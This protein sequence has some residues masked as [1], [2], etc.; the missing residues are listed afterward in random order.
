M[1]RLTL[2]LQSD[3][4]A[5]CRLNPD[6]PVPAWADGPGFVSITRTADELS[7]VCAQMRVPATVKA[8]TGWRAFKVA[9]PL[10]FSLIGILAALVQP[11][12]AAKISV[13][14]VSTFDTDYLLVKATDVHATIRTWQN[15]GYHITGAVD[16]SS[17][18][19]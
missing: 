3:L 15:A 12:A 16:D 11:L 10:D 8:E 19:S 18:L 2:S 7:V 14:T 9:G 4:L 5:V 17:T 13:F 6:V 1:T